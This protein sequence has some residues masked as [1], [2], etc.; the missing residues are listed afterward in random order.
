MTKSWKGLRGPI[1][2]HAQQERARIRKEQLEKLRQLPEVG[3]QEAEPD[4]VQLLKE[5]KANITKEE[6]AERIRQFHAAVSERQS[7]DRE[8]S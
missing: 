7:R 1:E 2:E 4:Y 6:L 5:W 8:S 3:G